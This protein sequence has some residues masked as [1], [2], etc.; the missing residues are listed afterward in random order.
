M[1]L[2][3]IEM[4][5]P[6]KKNWAYSKPDKMPNR[7]IEIINPKLITAEASPSGVLLDGRGKETEITFKP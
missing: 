5:Y 2:E 6:R 1:L 4:S 3:I 7:A